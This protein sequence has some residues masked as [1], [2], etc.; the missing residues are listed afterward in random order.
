MQSLPHPNRKL[1]AVDRDRE[2]VE[3]ISVGHQFMEP[4]H[5]F[6]LGPRQ[7]SKLVVYCCITIANSLFLV[8]CVFRL[9]RE[10]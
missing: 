9:H 2:S 10:H 6:R 3:A 8:K 1:P 7:K 5:H 4:I